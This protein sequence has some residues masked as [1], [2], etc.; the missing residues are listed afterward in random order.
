[1]IRNF[2][3]QIKFDPIFVDVPYQITRVDEERNLLEVRNKD[4]T[5]LRHPD[6]VK[7]WF[8]LQPQPS[9]TQA[10]LTHSSTE[11][12]PTMLDDESNSERGLFDDDLNENQHQDETPL[13]RR[14]SRNRQPNTLYTDFVKY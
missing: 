8:D 1:M 5:L 3:R 9:T 4:S 2:K 6:D 11:E 10:T 7:P 14:S 12:W 13:P